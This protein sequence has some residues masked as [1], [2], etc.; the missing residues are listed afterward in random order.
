VAALSTYFQIITPLRN[1]TKIFSMNNT[2][3]VPFVI[4][5]YTLMDG[6]LVVSSF[7]ATTY[8]IKLYKINGGF[9]IRTLRNFILSKLMRIIPLYYIVFFFGWCI[10]SRLVNTQHFHEFTW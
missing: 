10:S 4:N 2:P 7:I 6:I 1:V 3:M 5:T 8:G 9:C